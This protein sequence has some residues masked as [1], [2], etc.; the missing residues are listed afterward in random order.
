MQMLISE[1]RIRLPSIDVSI[2][3]I[4]PVEFRL[5]RISSAKCRF[6]MYQRV[7]KSCARPQACCLVGASNAVVVSLNKFSQIID[8]N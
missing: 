8:K 5:L 7:D 2:A 1:R 3:S 6:T 4:S